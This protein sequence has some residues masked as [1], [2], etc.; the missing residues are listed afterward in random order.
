MTSE[1]GGMYMPVAPAYSV[2]NAGGGI[3]LDGFGGGWTLLLL[4]IVLGGWGGG[5]GFGGGMGGMMW[6][7]MMGMGGGLGLEYMYPWLNNSQHISDGFRDQNIQNGISGIQNG[8]TTG[9]GNVQL[10]QAG[11]NQNICQAGNAITGAIRDGFYGAEIAANG[12]QATNMQQMFGVQSAIQNCCCQ[13]SANTA[14][15]KY[16]VATEACADRSAIQNALRDVLEA[17]NASTQRILDTMCQDK[18]DAKNER[19]AELQQQLYMKDLAASQTA[20]TAAIQAGQRALANEVEQ[21]IHPNPIPAYQVASPYCC[22]QNY[23][24]GCGA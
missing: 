19:I 9:F 17:N 22:N 20:Q 11:I 13:Q 4:L 12:R 1:N 2:G 21:Y 18:I 16:T 6:P 3:G 7:M 5:F 15:L 23:G 10:G 14:D 24:C 8:M